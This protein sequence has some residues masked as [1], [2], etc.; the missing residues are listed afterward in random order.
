M[1][2][3]NKEND[4]SEAGSS[5]MTKKLKKSRKIEVGWLHMC[6]EKNRYI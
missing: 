3:K 2:I 4:S 1:A 6:P 5:G